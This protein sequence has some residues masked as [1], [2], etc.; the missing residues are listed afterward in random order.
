M[1]LTLAR[2]KLLSKQ[3]AFF[4]KWRYVYSLKPYGMSNM[5][6]ILKFL[7]FLFY[8]YY[9]FFTMNYYQYLLSVLMLK[10]ISIFVILCFHMFDKMTI[11]V[12]NKKKKK[13]KKQKQKQRWSCSCRRRDRKNEYWKMLSIIYYKS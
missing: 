7:F 5:F 9:Y 2:K 11:R 12:I 3:Q 1:D 4:L 8:Y 10:I 13:Q 6:Y